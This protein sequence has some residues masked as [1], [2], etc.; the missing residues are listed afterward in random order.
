MM[1]NKMMKI[2][3]SF[4]LLSMVVLLFASCGTQ[5][6]NKKAQKNDTNRTIVSG[7]N[8]DSAY[9][10]TA[11]QVA[12]GPRVPGTKAHAQC[13]SWMINKLKQFSDTVY[14]QKFKARTYDGVTR[15]GI[16]IIGSVNPDET[17]RVLL[18]AHWDSRPFAD[19]DK[20]PA[21][22]HKPIDAANDGASGVAV[23]LELMRQF[24]LNNPE[25]GVD[26]LLV[27]LEDWGPPDFESHPYN[28]NNWG[29]GS[30]YWAKTPHIPGY[31][32]NYGIL[33]DMV[34]AKNPTFKKEYYSMGFASYVVNEVWR[35][36]DEL[37][38]GE[39]F[40]NAEGGAISDD[41]IFI[42]KYRNIPTIDIIHL[43]SHSSNGSFYEYWHTTGDTMDKIDKSTLLM[44]GKVVGTVVYNN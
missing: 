24:K 2:K 32:A 27:D 26:V 19:H 6:G 15:T 18:L 7:F 1:K 37:G 14:I 17:S 12:F 42:N 5:T 41:H 43:D 20:D 23:L 28:E 10:F 4:F 8:A 29:L 40:V 39:W 38:Y 16:N 34:G 31:Q 13:A 25:K 33:L 11:K 21:N 36:A 9:A 22:Y 35:T 30:Q 44:V 3:Y